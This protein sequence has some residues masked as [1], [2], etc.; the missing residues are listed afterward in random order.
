MIFYLASQHDSDEA[1][2]LNDEDIAI[3]T[4]GNYNSQLQNTERE[5][6]V[7]ESY[8]RES[9]DEEVHF[10]PTK[11]KYNGSDFDDDTFSKKQ[12]VSSQISFIVT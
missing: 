11:R 2:S 1:I 8:R 4:K 9:L 5:E 10:E 12:K 3:I 7:K 6:K